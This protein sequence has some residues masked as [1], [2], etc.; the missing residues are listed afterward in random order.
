M[1]YYF[2]YEKGELGTDAINKYIYN[3]IYTNDDGE[4]YKKLFVQDEKIIVISNTYNH[5]PARA[6]ACPS[7]WWG[8]WWACWG[9]HSP[10]SLA[11]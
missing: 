2:S 11:A 7:S 5:A 8:G 1:Y 4:N 9:V 10:S 3:Q 6:W